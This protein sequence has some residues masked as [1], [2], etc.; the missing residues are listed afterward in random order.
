MS[1]LTLHIPTLETDRVIL[2]AP[3]AEDFPVFDAFA[4]TDRSRFNG[5]PFADPYLRRRLFGHIAGIWVLRGY[6][7]YLIADRSSD[8]PL[9]IAGLWHPIGWPEPEMSWSLWAPEAE[10]QGIAHDAA[11]AAMADAFARVG[12]ATTVSYID[13]DNARSIALAKRL[14]AVLDAAAERPDPTDQVYR[15]PRPQ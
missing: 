10:G 11:R 5:G 4:Q 14:G 8:A 3:R 1:G 13:P 15:H 7:P 9:G 2:R 6:G 12:L